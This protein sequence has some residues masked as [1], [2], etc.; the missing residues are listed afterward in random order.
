MCDSA[1]NN[2]QQHADHTPS[3]NTLVKMATIPECKSNNAYRQDANK[4][5]NMEMIRIKLGQER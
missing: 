5:L 4:H 2:Q 1:T 3:D